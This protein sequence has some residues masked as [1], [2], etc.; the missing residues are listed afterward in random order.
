VAF[1]AARWSPL[2]HS[3]AHPSII[4]PHLATILATPHA[5]RAIIVPNGIGCVPFDFLD[6]YFQSALE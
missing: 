5:P 6:A 4:H 2:T 1:A 3:H